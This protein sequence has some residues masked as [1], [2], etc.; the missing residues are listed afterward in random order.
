MHLTSDRIPLRQVDIALPAIVPIAGRKAEQRTKRYETDEKTAQLQT[1]CRLMTKNWRL[2]SD[3]IA[4][5]KLSTQR[6]R[7]LFLANL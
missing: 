7:S 4:A 5:R 3:C 6:G 2:T 1:L